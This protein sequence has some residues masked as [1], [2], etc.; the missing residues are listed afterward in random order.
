MDKLGAELRKNNREAYDWLEA[1]T[2]KITLTVS[3][4]TV[5]HPCLVLV[6]AVI[7]SQFV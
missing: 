7:M 6:I 2:R 1:R 4:S 3:S 5:I